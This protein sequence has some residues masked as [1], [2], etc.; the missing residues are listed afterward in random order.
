MPH[1][2]RIFDLRKQSKKMEQTPSP[3]KLYRKNAVKNFNYTPSPSSS[4][5]PSTC[6]SPAHRARSL[7]LPHEVDRRSF[8]IDGNG[9]EINSVIKSLGFSGPEDFEIPKAAWEAMKSRSPSDVT[10]RPNTGYNE[11]DETQNEEVQKVVDASAHT[12]GN[13]DQTNGAIDVDT[14][15]MNGA[16]DVDTSNNKLKLFGAAV[17]PLNDTT[18]GAAGKGG[19]IKGDRPPLL[20]PPPAMSLPILDHECSTWEIVKGL[21]PDGH[22]APRFS[23]HD[24]SHLSE[25]EEEGDGEKAHRERLDRLRSGGLIVPSGSCS[26]TTTNDDDSSST[27][28]EPVSIISP[29]GGCRLNITHWEKGVL[30]GRG[31][32]GT[33][34]EGISR[35]VLLLLISFV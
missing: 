10:L 11:P 27:T 35:Y 3:R 6:S 26:F 24:T 9:S 5:S 14:D 23:Y 30:L 32:F 15:N 29:N 25:N 17:P 8:R 4:T 31:S 34:Y 20:T 33:V 1:L 22:I 13:G 19:G 18:V 28:T 7:D 2:P 12:N 21:A 16:I